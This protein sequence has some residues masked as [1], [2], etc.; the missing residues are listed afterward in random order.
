MFDELIEGATS[1]L[2]EFGDGPFRSVSRL[3]LG[4]FVW[5]DTCILVTREISDHKDFPGLSSSTRYCPTRLR[6]NG[7]SM[8]PSLVSDVM[9]LMA[10]RPT[11]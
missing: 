2:P 11:D 9:K 7:S 5:S 4:Y 6:N 10:L 1:E 3:L 8:G